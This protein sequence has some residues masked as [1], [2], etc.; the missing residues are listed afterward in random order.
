MQ[1]TKQNFHLTML[2]VA[3]VIAAMAT[4][5]V[6][7]GV[8]YSDSYGRAEYA[9]IIAFG[10]WPEGFIP[11][12]TM[13]P[14]VYIAFFYWLTNSY[15]V[16]TWVQA[17]FFLW[18]I[19]E[20]LHRIYEGNKRA[21][22][23]V[24]LLF[25]P[26]FVGY[27]VYWETG[28]LTACL[29]G[30]LLWLDHDVE[31]G[32]N[33]VLTVF[34]FALYTFICFSVTGYRINAATAIVG[35][36]LWNAICVLRRRQKIIRLVPKC[37]AAFLGIVL[38]LQVP[39]FLGLPN[40]NN[41]M[42]GVLWET[43]AMIDRIG[44][45]QGYDHYLDEIIGEGNT[46]QLFTVEEPESSMYAFSEIF[47]YWSIVKANPDAIAKKYIEIVFAEP[48]T[49]VKVKA[50]IVWNTLTR[51]RFGE[52]APNPGNGMDSLG[53]SDTVR[54][55]QAIK[56]VNWY[57]EQI[58]LLRI[59]L[60]MFGTALFLLLICLRLHLSTSHLFKLIFVVLCYEGGYFI[61]T[62][63][64][65]FRYFFPGWLLLLFAILSALRSIWKAK[66]ET[67]FSAAKQKIC[68]KGIRHELR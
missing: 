41:A 51:S 42:T 15:A 16:Y 23:L 59:P 31:E 11:Y 12:I 47:D 63:A 46:E 2:V 40:T 48:G 34:Q 6:Y 3:V 45:D 66:I 4:F 17:S 36:L 14:S 44:P 18:S 33:K 1:K 24:F 62:Q 38:A 28:V 25:S 27:S 56:A 61:T 50:N 9:E 35:L 29:L 54:R 8:L 30:S 58:W 32:D 39:T 49:F 64:Y 21:V 68:R 7:P 13:L 67:K 52:Y 55:D 43:C 53:F 26:L 65:E 60:F 22:V 20:M 5:V 10:T 57:M 37:V 19:F